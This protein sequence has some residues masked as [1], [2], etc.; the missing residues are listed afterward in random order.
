M[1]MP[2]AL[3][4]DQ[5]EALRTLVRE[6]A[7]MPAPQADENPEVSRARTIAVTSGKGGVGKSNLAVNLAI[8]MSKLGRRVVLLDADLGTANA[9]VLLNV[10]PRVNLAHVVAGRRTLGEATIET[11]SG[12]RLVPGASGLAAM[13]ALGESGRGQLID[14]LT[15]LERD[16]DVII[17]DTGA[18]V[19]PN[20]LGF[21]G[22]AD[23]VLVVTTPEP[24][25]IADAYALIKTFGRSQDQVAFADA[26][27]RPIDVVV[28]MCQDEEQARSV[29]GR[30]DRVSRHFLN[31]S[32]RF[33]G[34]LPTDSQVRQAVLRRSP[35]MVNSPTC[36][37]SQAVIQLAHRMDRDAVSPRPGGMFERMASWF[38]G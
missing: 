21:L 16:T 19:S 15:T 37:V 28:N 3:D 24:T 29:F 30:L 14:S 17:V 32:L 25:A 5:A 2:M 34:C 13:A 33:G 36:R 35:F 1:I 4:A 31:R 8:A 10:N 27:R 6:T 38:G 23:E 11:A 26:K 12:V 18:G 20:V 7:E 9:D 22:A